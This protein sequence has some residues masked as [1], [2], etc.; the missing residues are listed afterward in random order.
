[1]SPLPYQADT[2]EK[3]SL[4]NPSTTVP[5]SS[6]GKKASVAMIIGTLFVAGNSWKKGPTSDSAA[7]AVSFSHL[8]FGDSN[9][10]FGVSHD[11]CDL[12]PAGDSKVQCTCIYNGM[13]GESCNDAIL[14]W[15]YTQGQG[16]CMESYLACDAEDFPC[17]FGFLSG[18]L[19]EDTKVVQ[20]F[21][22][23]EYDCF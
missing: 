19:A 22:K 14:D 17:Y 4:V 2:T 12:L 7:A 15:A 18:C 21:K 3:I 20:C 5:V 23:Y 11:E 9:L 1:M 6:M 10:V 13:E 8:T 16:S